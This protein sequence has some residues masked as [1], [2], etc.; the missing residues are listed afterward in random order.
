MADVTAEERRTFAQRGW[1]MPDGSYYIRPD[2]PEDLTNAIRAVGRATQTG[3]PRAT[4]EA[5]R[6][7]VR[8]HVMKRARALGRSDEIPDTWN[9]DGTLKQWALTEEFLAHFGVR[10]M[11]WGVRRERSAASAESVRART[12]EDQ[13]R[14]SGSQSLSNKDLQDLVTRLNLEKQY[15][16]LN[17]K[18]V[19]AGRKIAQDILRDSAKQI[20]TQFIVKNAPKAIAAGITKGKVGYSKQVDLQ[21]RASANRVAGIMRR[22]GRPVS[23]DYVRETM[24][25]AGLEK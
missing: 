18:Q 1:A 24:R 13:I 9:P 19:S 23:P 17:Q 25:K 6:N 3:T 2:H 4:D 5:Q 12:L 8:R 20:A 22:S 16:Q 14:R 21:N 11:R 15:G 10:G 7:A